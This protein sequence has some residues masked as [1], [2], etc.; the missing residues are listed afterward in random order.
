[1]IAI[2]FRSFSR[3][4][5]R[6]SINPCAAS[7]GSL[8]MFAAIRRASAAGNKTPAVGVHS[9]SGSIISHGQP[10]DKK[11]SARQHLHLPLPLFSAPPSRHWLRPSTIIAAPTL[12]LL[13][14]AVRRLVAQLAVV[15]AQ[16]LALVHHQIGT[17]A[18]PS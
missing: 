15:L 11:C 17:S 8:A 14:A 10:G 4:H 9:E 18:C 5:L 12:P 2:T 3:A 6:A 16:D 13:V 7:W 1:M